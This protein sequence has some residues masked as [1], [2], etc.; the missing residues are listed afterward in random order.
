MESSF[1]LCKSQK[2]ITD[3]LHLEIHVVIVKVPMVKTFL[4]GDLAELKYDTLF[5]KI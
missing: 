4:Q 2:T 1:V 3:F 5:L